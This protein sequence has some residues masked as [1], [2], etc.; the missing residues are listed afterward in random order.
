MVF[1]SSCEGVPFKFKKKTGGPPV[2]QHRLFELAIDPSQN[3]LDITYKQQDQS[4][5][6]KKNTR[7][8]QVTGRTA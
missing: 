5:G 2:Y 4:T 6:R 1:C 3:S 8:Y 7:V